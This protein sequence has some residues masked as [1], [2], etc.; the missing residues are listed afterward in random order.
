MTAHPNFPPMLFGTSDP[1]SVATPAPIGILLMRLDTGQVY[2]KT[3]K[4][5]TAWTLL[6]LASFAGDRTWYGSG[7]DGNLVVL[8][9]TVVTLGD[10]DASSA[11]FLA[12]N[13]VTVQTGACLYTGGYPLIVAGTLTI[14]GTGTVEA[15]GMNGGSSGGG[16]GGTGGGGITKSGYTIP[17]YTNYANGSPGGNGGSTGL[18]GGGADGIRTLNLDTGGAGG[19]GGGIGGTVTANGRSCFAS[20]WISLGADMGE[21]ASGLAGNPIGGGAGGGGGGGVDGAGGG[22]GGGVLRV[23]ARNIVCPNG[24]I[25]TTGGNGGNSPGTDGGGGGGMG[26]V[27]LLITDGPFSPAAKC[28]VTGGVGGAGAA[29]AGSPGDPGTVVAISP[30]LG[31]L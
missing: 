23:Y 20:P 7:V 13:N 14:E 9:G 25:K 1:T 16:G 8:T 18:N 27:L 2:V 26:G 15:S 11:A 29:G 10:I 31:P 21:F 22:G 6:A 19:G 3:G 17:A 12:F 28:D 4:A 24:A 30:T 5:D